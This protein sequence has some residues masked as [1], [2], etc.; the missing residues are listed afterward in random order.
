VNGGAGQ[1]GRSHIQL[2]IAREAPHP[3]RPEPGL[4]PGP[5]LCMMGGASTED[6][7][8]PDIELTPW[9]RLVLAFWALFAVL[10]RAEVAREVSRVRESRRAS[11]PPPSPGARPE[12]AWTAPPPGAPAPKAAPPPA[13][14]AKAAPLPAAPPPSVAP[15]AATQATAKPAPVTVAPKPTLVPPAA[16]AVPD[17]RGALLVLSVL[18][19]EGRLVDFLEEDLAGFPDSSIGA[20]ARTV[21]AGCKRAIQ[22]LFRLEPIYRE[23]EGAQ[24]TVASGFDPAAIRLTGN[25]VGKPPFKGS[26]RHHGWRAREVKLPPVEVKDP[27][28]LAPAEVEL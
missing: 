27:N 14:P 28:I 17:A 10:F 26:L 16:P 8:M 9:Q 13:A 15:P 12:P 11:L 4:V 3:V 25:V 23:A 2:F 7:S 20:A 18:Q 19:R 21:H 24:V 22:E 5:A 1:T 6:P